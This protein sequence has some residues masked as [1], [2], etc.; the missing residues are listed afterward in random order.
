M[1]FDSW[2]IQLTIC[3]IFLFS[4]QMPLHTYSIGAGQGNC[5]NAN[6]TVPIM[7]CLGHHTPGNSFQ[8]IHCLIIDHAKLWYKAYTT[9]CNCKPMDCLMY[10]AKLP[11]IRCLKLI[12]GQ[13]QAITDCLKDQRIYKLSFTQPLYAVIIIRAPIK[14]STPCEWTAVRPVKWVNS[15]ICMKRY[16]ALQYKV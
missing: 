4:T 1:Q 2:S 6:G 14:M 16:P 7:L 3:N 10:V 15:S 8:A 13:L 5:D 9:R 11:T 12:H